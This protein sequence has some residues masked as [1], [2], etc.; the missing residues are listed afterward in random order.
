VPTGFLFKTY[1]AGGA[2][3]KHVVFVPRGYTPE[4]EWPCVVFL[5]GAGECGTDGLKQVA[6][7]LGQAVLWDEK[8]WPCLVIFPQKPEVGKAWED[9]DAVVMGMLE[10][11]RM[12][13]RVDASRIA[14]TGLSQGGHGSWTLGAAHA[15][16]WSAVA[17]I[18]GYV[19]RDHRTGGV[20]TAEAA[21]LAGALRSTPVWAFHGEA[22][23]AVKA[24]QTRAMVEAF[25]G[26]GVTVKASFYPGVNHNS[27]DR[28]YREEREAG[29]L[30][31]WL[32]GQRRAK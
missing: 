24:E 26:L 22:D 16:V 10:Q 29:G 18:C 7:G 25:K 27:W 28:A 31:A 8:A 11:V 9:Y 23:E 32:L 2:E 15:D 14:L 1:A 6:Q 12:E 5:H 21:R 19:G 20:D 3:Y 17:P 30:A 4:K 13:Y